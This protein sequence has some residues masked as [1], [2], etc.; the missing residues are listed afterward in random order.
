VTSPPGPR[1]TV[2]DVMRTGIVTCPPDATL[3]T[4]AAI[5]AEHRIHAVVVAQGDEGAPCAVVTDRDVV[6]GHA[7]GELDR[8]TS[9]DA[10]TEPTVTVRADLDLREA[11]KL[12]AHYGTSHVIVT[13]SGGRNPIG[14]LSSLDV[15]AAIAAT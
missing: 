9:R 3:R 4:V 12:M 1:N 2:G 11:S 10:A 13:A 6:A 15:A 14:I 7:R 5:L 8:V